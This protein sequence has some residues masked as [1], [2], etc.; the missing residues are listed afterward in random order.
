[1]SSPPCSTGS[2][3]VR[4][5]P[6]ATPSVR[7][8][9]LA[10]CSCA[11]AQGAECH[12]GAT[13]AA[14]LDSGSASA[15]T[16][17]R[18]LLA[19]RLVDGVVRHVGVT[20]L[21]GVE[22]RVQVGEL[23]R[24][25]VD[26]RLVVLGWRS[27][28]ACRKTSWAPSRLARKSTRSVWLK[29]SSSPVILPVATS[30]SSSLAPLAM[31]VALMVAVGAF[32]LELLQ[33]PW[34]AG[35]H[36]S[37]CPW[38]SWSTHSDFSMRCQPV[39]FWP[40]SRSASRRSIAGSRSPKLS[41]TGSMLSQPKRDGAYSCLGLGDVAGLDRRGELRRS[42]RWW[43]RPACGR[44]PG[45]PRPLRLPR[46]PGSASGGVR[47]DGQRLADAVADLARLAGDLVRAGGQ[48]DG[49]V[50][51]DA[52][53]DV[54][55]LGEDAVAVAVDVDLG[56]LRSLVGDRRGWTGPATT[57]VA[58]DVARGV[59][60]S[61]DDAVP[62]GGAATFGRGAGREGGD[63]GH[64]GQGQQGGVSTWGA[65]WR[66]L[67]FWRGG[68]SELGEP[69]LSTTTRLLRRRI[70]NVCGGAVLSVFRHEACW[71]TGRSV[72]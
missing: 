72:R 66:N 8:P 67:Q 14:S 32:S 37:P 54:L 19:L 11:V 10:R 71:G 17:V 2:R 41:A 43:P 69:Y 56:D 20:A 58:V 57:L 15:L 34:S 62:G 1:M 45:R 27:A 24:E 50:G 36:R 5:S 60:G 70:R 47:G 53:T 55:P 30:S 68:G 29:I 18:E 52:G 26:Q 38:S 23:R 22:Q 33:G 48:V 6:A 51:R 40:S 64:C 61:D 44:T 21:V 13:A 65:T 12:R 3:P 31:D 42:P 63:R 9:D 4:C 25:L 39:H 59:T 28:P 49:E 46:R 7:A 35:R 16:R